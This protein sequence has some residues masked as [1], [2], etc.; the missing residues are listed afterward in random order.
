MLQKGEAAPNF[1]GVD[2]FGN[3]I[4]LANFRTKKVVLYFYPKDDTPGCTKEA[5]NLRDNYEALQQNGY[6]IIGVSPD[7]KASHEKFAEKYN[8]P[9]SLIADSNHEIIHRYGVWGTKNMYGKLYEGLL[10]TTFVIN[11]DGIIEEVIKKVKTDN[12]TQQIIH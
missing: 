4:E 6:V 12:H 3:H 2:Q 1:S 10:R 5:C 7:D 9:F 8:L 11:E